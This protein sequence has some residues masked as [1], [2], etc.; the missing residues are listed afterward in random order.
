MLRGAMSSTIPGIPWYRLTVIFLLVVSVYSFKYVKSDSKFYHTKNGEVEYERD[1]KIY[2]IGRIDFNSV[3]IKGRPTAT[4]D[5]KIPPNQ[6]KNGKRHRRSASSTAESVKEKEQKRRSEYI[7]KDGLEECL[8]MEYEDQPTNKAFVMNHDDKILWL[9]VVIPIME[10]D[11]KINPRRG[12]TNFQSLRYAVELA[13]AGMKSLLMMGGWTIRLRRLYPSVNLGDPSLIRYGFKCRTSNVTAFYGPFYQDN[14]DVLAAMTHIYPITFMSQSSS[15]ENDD[16]LRYQFG[17]SKN[18]IH[19]Y[20]L[21]TNPSTL[22][23]NQV[24]L[25][26]ILKFGWNFVAVFHSSFYIGESTSD[27]LFLLDK[28]GICIPSTRLKGGIEGNTDENIKARIIELRE[29]H[30]TLRVL[31]LLTDVADTRSVLKAIKELD[32]QNHFTLLFAD[33]GVNDI[34]VVRGY[35]DIAVGAIT[36]EPVNFHEKHLEQLADFEQWML[37]ANPTNTRNLYFHWYWEQTFECELNSHILDRMLTPDQRGTYQKKCTGDEQFQ[38]GKGVYP[39]RNLFRGAM[40]TVEA[41]VFTLYRM[42]LISTQSCEWVTS[43]KDLINIWSK[44]G[45]DKCPWNT[46]LCFNR[47]FEGVFPSINMLNYQRLL[48][49]IG[50]SLKYNHPRDIP[51]ASYE[52]SNFIFTNGRYQSVPHW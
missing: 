52:I 8:P 11:F 9:G 6:M 19:K 29:N 33:R 27:V 46:T 35:E 48:P 16:R 50:W 17:K 10:T 31:L 5:F 49:D 12:M 3:K 4:D 45:C 14:Y 18:Q 26:I 34:E 13:N 25:D 30:P 32:L 24:I 23:R 22:F 47:F 42:E 2:R 20:T 28:S 44:D 1:G 7:N 15:K 51:N 21:Q 39:D 37:K 41:I 36:I 38:I 40:D 43:N